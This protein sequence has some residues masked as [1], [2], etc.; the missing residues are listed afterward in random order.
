MVDAKGQAIVTGFNAAPH[1]GPSF[2]DAQQMCQH[3]L[4]VATDC[5]PRAE[6]RMRIIVSIMRR[7]RMLWDDLETV[8]KINHGIGVSVSLVFDGQ[9]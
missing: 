6:E 1:T 4:D 9:C 5:S 2:A 7:N 8:E 3:I